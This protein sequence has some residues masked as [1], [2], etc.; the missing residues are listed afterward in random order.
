MKIVSN[1]TGKISSTLFSKFA[2]EKAFMLECN[3][4]YIANW[5]ILVQTT[6]QLQKMRYR[7]FFRLY[8]EKEKTAYCAIFKL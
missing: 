6:W 8:S 3:I 4:S 7:K 2:V 5:Y 1:V